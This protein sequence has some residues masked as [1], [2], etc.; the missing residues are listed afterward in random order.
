MAGITLG[1]RVLARKREARPRVIEAVDLAPPIGQGGGLAAVFLVAGDAALLLFLERRMKAA[2]TSDRR[3]Q[4][5]VAAQAQLAIDLLPN[6]VTLCAVAQA[7]ERG[8]RPPEGSRR[9]DL[10]DRM[11]NRSGNRE[12][13]DAHDGND[14]EH[15]KIHR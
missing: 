13:H 4:F 15:Q 10:C 11:M 2:T 7:L 1:L 9:K 5:F 14:S 6:I 12:G 3:L 8:V